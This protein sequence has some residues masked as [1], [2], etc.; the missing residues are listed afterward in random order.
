MMAL[1]MLADVL[2]GRRQGP[3]ALFTGVGT[4]SRTLRRGDLFVALVGDRFDGHQFLAEALAAGAAG[5]LLARDVNT[6]LPT[7]QVNDT[8]RGFGE[9]AAFWRAQFDI[10]VIAVTGS[11]GKTTVKE[12][13]GAI[14]GRGARGCVTRGNLNNDIGVP[15]TLCRL[16]AEDRYAVIEMGMNH[17]GEIDYLTRLTH[18]TAAVI[19]N[20]AEAHLEA[21]GSIDDVAHAKGEIFAGLTGDGIAIINDDD[22][23]AGLWRALA[24]PHRVVTFGLDR[25]PDV[26][27]HYTL[28]RAGADLTLQTPAGEQYVRLP[29]L[30]RHNVLN[31]L[32]ATA[33]AL[34]AGAT[35]A[36]VR[37]GLESVRPVPGRLEVKDGVSGARVIDDTYNANPASL[38]ASLEVLKEFQGD[39]MLVLGNM[40]ELGEQGGELHRRVGQT[41]KAMG[42]QRLYAFGDLAALAAKA[43]GKAGRA[44]D[45]PEAL[46]DA[47]IDVMHS[48]MTVLVKGSRAAH[49]ERIVHGI[50]RGATEPVIDNPEN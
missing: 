28:S 33:A 31:A 47:L 16:T 40:G 45:R 22:P 48:G 4:D 36:D 49:M 46:I 39:R 7:V 35:L 8:R 12:M 21:L 5:A 24:A 29:M 37:S 14:L 41:A 15:L 50:L 34:A 6:T 23:H 32:A 3:D 19:T 9:L 25:R 10:P 18:P 20:A 27:A 26:T 30:G 11:N 17:K 44:F 38:A 43:F 13:I 2:K 42:I 1:S